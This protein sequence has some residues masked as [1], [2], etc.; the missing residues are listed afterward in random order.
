MCFV[1]S[2][3]TIK[4]SLKNNIIYVLRKE[5]KWNPIK[6]SIKRRLNKF[7]NERED[8]GFISYNKGTNLVGDADSG[9]N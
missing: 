6:C 4:E 8:L 3:T 7:R 5:R 1:N 9:I 2:R